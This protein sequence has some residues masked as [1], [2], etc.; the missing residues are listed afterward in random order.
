M[1]PQVS[2]VRQQLNDGS[3]KELFQIVGRLVD[4]ERSRG[5]GLETKTST[6]AGFT[7]AILALTATLGRD[8][9]KLDM[10]SVGDVAQGALFAVAVS[11]LAA[12]SVIAVLGVLRPQQRLAVARSELRRFAEFPLLATPPVEIQGRMIITLVDALENE[13]RVND[14]KA[15]LSRW[16][17]FALAVGLLGVAGQ[18]ITMLASGA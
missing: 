8:L 18:A 15:N 13:R 16:A 11:A 3:V 14:R 2:D 10:G 17:G 1:T 6:L 7:G 12:G 5:Q 9:L 4:D